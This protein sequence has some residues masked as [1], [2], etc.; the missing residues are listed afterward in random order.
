MR[1]VSPFVFTTFILLS[2]FTVFNVTSI[3]YSEYKLSTYEDKI[4]NLN[5]KIINLKNI[6]SQAKLDNHRLKDIL[7]TKQTLDKI[8][9]EQLSNNALIRYSTIIVDKAKKYNVDKNL[10]ISLIA[11]ESSFKN[12]AVSHIGAVGLMQLLPSTA[13]YIS[14]KY[15][16]KNYND[17]NDLYNPI[18]NVELGI[19][20]FDYLVGK[21][22]SIDHA[23][24]AYNYGPGNLSKAIK[25]NKKLPE[26]YHNKVVKNLYKINSSK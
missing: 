21:T 14:K 26:S 4:N 8:S 2:V 9:N 23:I 22:G 18:I 20:Y 7:E 3:F 25:N 17:I 6:N 11:T 19:A 12:D 16:I 13:K 24:I 15:K 10:I 1:S 5:E